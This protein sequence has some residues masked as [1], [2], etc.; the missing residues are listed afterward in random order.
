MIATLSL[1]FRRP[2]SLHSFNVLKQISSKLLQKVLTHTT[3]KPSMP[4][5]E[6]GFMCWNN[7]CFSSF[8]VSSPCNEFLSL[9]L[10]F[11]FLALVGPPDLPLHLEMLGY[12]L[13]RGEVFV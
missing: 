2:F 3:V 8:L 5:A 6:F 1:Q 13:F 11:Q 10:S 7:W 9:L 4:G 12:V